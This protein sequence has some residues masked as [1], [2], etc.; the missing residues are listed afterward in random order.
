MPQVESEIIIEADRN[1]VYA[2]AKDV[3]KFPEFLPDVQSV[4][5]LEREGSRVVSEWVGII[6]QFNRTLHWTEEDDWDDAQRQCSFRAISGDWDKYQGVWKFESHPQGTRVH[7]AVEYE[8][9]VPL[10]GPL[11]KGVLTKLVKHNCDQMLEG[12]RQRVTE[13]P[14]V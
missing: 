2:V 4:K 6:K 7:L 14:N 9:D 3:E 5:V 12:L 8:F 10:I 1:R 11:I 13:H